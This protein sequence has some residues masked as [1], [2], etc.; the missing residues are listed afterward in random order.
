MHIAQYIVR[1]NLVKRL[2]FSFI[3]RGL[4]LIVVYL[5]RQEKMKLV[6]EMKKYG[7]RTSLSRDV[8][9]SL[10]RGGVLCVEMEFYVDISRE[11]RCNIEINV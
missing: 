11:S 4:C 5:S 10:N 2:K 7:I 8:G 3:I 6:T 9:K 1:L